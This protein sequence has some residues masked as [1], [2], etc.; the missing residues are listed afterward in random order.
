MRCPLRGLSDWS[1]G[2]G[3]EISVAS[4]EVLV[5]DFFW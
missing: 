1:A 5:V 2:P 4:L 3:R